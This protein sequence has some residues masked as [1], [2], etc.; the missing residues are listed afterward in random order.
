MSARS[1]ELELEDDETGGGHDT[2]TI[3]GELV[4]FVG[5]GSTPAAVVVPLI[6][7]VV[8]HVV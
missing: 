2:V 1:K 5:F 8:K 4:L 7:T 6:C 3:C